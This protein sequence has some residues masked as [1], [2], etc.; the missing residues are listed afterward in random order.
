M[1]PNCGWCRKAKKLISCY[2]VGVYERLTVFC[3]A[4]ERRFPA[5]P[6]PE[7]RTFVRCTILTLTTRLLHRI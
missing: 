1:R 6:P 5:A 2:S 7:K 4:R 3:L